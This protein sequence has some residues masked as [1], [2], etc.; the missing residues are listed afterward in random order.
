MRTGLMFTLE[1][2]QSLPLGWRATAAGCLPL[3]RWLCSASEVDLGLFVPCFP[4]R[5]PGHC[6][7]LP[8][9]LTQHCCG[10][11]FWCL[12]VCV[13]PEAVPWPSSCVPHGCVL[14]NQLWAAGALK[15]AGAPSPWDFRH[16]VPRPVLGCWVIPRDWHRNPECQHATCMA[17]A[18]FT[19]RSRLFPA[20]SLV[21]AKGLL[22][23]RGHS[24]CL[25]M[26]INPSL[27]RFPSVNVRPP[28]SLLVNCV[29]GGFLLL[30]FSL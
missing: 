3:H 29:L 16:T 17:L 19:G 2:G 20:A 24:S 27:P 21:L 4:Q 13:R 30:L 12:S 9:S 18:K 25:N 1:E 5:C 15:A 11:S 26:R 22:W 7:G 10:G 23:C 28:T 8:V 6:R 14:R